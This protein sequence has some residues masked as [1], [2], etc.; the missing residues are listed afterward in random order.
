[1][2][3]VFGVLY[4]I[5]L[6]Y[7]VTLYTILYRCLESR[8]KKCFDFIR[9][10]KEKFVFCPPPS[11]NYTYTYTYHAVFHRSMDWGGSNPLEHARAY[12]IIITLVSLHIYVCVCVCRKIASI[13]LENNI[14]LRWSFLFFQRTFE[15]RNKKIAI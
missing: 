7:C 12:S 5:L 15:K 2:V 3:I 8:K 14:R 4:I 10:E 6:K 13:I 9:C 11:E 1:M